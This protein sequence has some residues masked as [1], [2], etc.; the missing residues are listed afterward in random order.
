MIP[1]FSPNIYKGAYNRLTEMEVDVETAEYEMD[2]GVLDDQIAKERKSS[3]SFI[4]AKT[5]KIIPQH[6]LFGV[7][8]GIRKYA[9][10]LMA[11]VRQGVIYD[12]E[13][14]AL[15]HAEH[16]HNSYLYMAVFLGSIALI[17]FIIFLW[18]VYR[19][20][21]EFFRVCRDDNELRLINFGFI[22]GITGYLI[23][24]FF[25]YQLFEKNSSTPFWVIVGLSLSLL[26]HV[27]P[28]KR[29]EK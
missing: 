23:A 28:Q 27:E 26:M 8:W 4:W 2:G 21:I 10:S 15:I 14:W 18:N 17:V 7:G 22:C 24:V 12:T 9:R 5:I 1:V 11:L 3:R 16:P 20:G 29:I 25:D 6:P 19:S 13:A